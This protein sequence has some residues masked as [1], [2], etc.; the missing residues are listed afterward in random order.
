M[1]L[2]SAAAVSLALGRGRTPA[3]ARALKWHRDH[4]MVATARDVRRLY[5]DGADGADWYLGAPEWLERRWGSSATTVAY[6]L[7]AT[8]PLASVRLNI[9]RTKFVLESLFAGRQW[10]KVRMGPAAPAI[11]RNVIRVWHEGLPPSGPK[12]SAFAAAILGDGEAVTVDRWMYTAWYGRETGTEAQ[13]ELIALWVRL[14]AQEVGRTPRDVQ[15][16]VW[17]GV[18]RREGMRADATDEPLVELLEQEWPA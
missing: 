1:S 2:D 9:K 17:C 8:S 3:G 13:R 5:Q 10:D 6:L 4:G 11:R 15:A 12:C 14:L 18:K 7:A 16:A